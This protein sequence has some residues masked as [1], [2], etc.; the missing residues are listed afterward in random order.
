MV[1]NEETLTSYLNTQITDIDFSEEE[2][3]IA[4]AIIGNI[5]EKGYFPISIEDFCEHEK[6]DLD[7]VE[8]V[9][10]TIQRLEPYGIAARDLKE[11]LL[12]QVR[13][14]NMKNGIIEVIISEHLSSLETRNVP[15]IA[16]ALGISNEKVVENIQLI[17]DLDPVPARQF[18]SSEQIYIVPDVYILKLTMKWVVSLNED[19]LPTLRV[20]RFYQEML[21][22]KTDERC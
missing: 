20:S 17:G 21:D 6:F 3:K 12:N 2:L 8:G 22:A 16:K 15:A 18:G 9:L 13:A 14:Y 1:S 5:D 11:C 4:V 7:L 19:G 10:D